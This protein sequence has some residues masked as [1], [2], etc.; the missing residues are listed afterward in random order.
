[1]KAKSPVR[2]K[3]LSGHEILLRIDTF[4]GH[5]KNPLEPKPGFF[6]HNLLFVLLAAKVIHDLWITGRFFI[7]NALNLLEH[8]MFPDAGFIAMI[9][10]NF[11]SVAIELF[12]FIQ[13]WKFTQKTKFSWILFNAVSWSWLFN[14]TFYI[15][16]QVIIASTND[17]KIKFNAWQYFSVSLPWIIFHGLII[18]MLTR[19]KIRAAHKIK[20]PHFTLAPIYG[21]AWTVIVY[22]LSGIVILIFELTK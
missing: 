17:F 9:V 1:M 15:I 16:S 8:S 18:Y 5:L 3:N 11:I 10:L 7:V 20:H 13:L 6:F 2:E 14:F 22:A 4:L 21:I 19:K 12:L